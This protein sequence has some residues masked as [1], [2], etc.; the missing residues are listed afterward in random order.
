M[1]FLQV[2]FDHLASKCTSGNDRELKKGMKT[3]EKLK[4][5]RRYQ[6]MEDFQKVIFHFLHF[7]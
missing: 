1:H 7:I 6:Q 4:L 3:S 2:I 5:R